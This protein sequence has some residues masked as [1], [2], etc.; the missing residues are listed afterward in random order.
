MNNLSTP[1]G[2]PTPAFYA[3]SGLKEFRRFCPHDKKIIKD[4][5]DFGLSKIYW[6]SRPGDLFEEIFGIPRS[7]Q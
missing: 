7:V 3:I 4:A 2:V 6:I 1:E 5:P